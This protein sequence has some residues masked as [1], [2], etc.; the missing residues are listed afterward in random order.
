MSIRLDTYPRPHWHLYLDSDLDS[1]NLGFIGSLYC[2]R[3]A[4]YCLGQYYVYT[5]DLRF[6]HHENFQVY[7]VIDD[8][9]DLIRVRSP[10]Q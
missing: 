9:G 4:R 2:E 6:P 1:M 5:L 3:H 8:Y 7:N 10:I